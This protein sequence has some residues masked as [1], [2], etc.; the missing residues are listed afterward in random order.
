MYKLPSISFRASKLAFLTDFRMFWNE[1]ICT[2]ICEVNPLKLKNIKTL[3]G[4][5]QNNRQYSTKKLF[6]KYILHTLCYVQKTYIDK[7]L[8][9]QG[10]TNTQTLKGFRG[11]REIKSTL[12]IDIIYWKHWGLHCHSIKDYHSIWPAHDK[13]FSVVDSNKDW[14]EYQQ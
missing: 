1:R 12:I 5:L 7:S 8:T 13:L 6:L 10:V 3:Y 2:N 14:S 9:W 4:Y 11:G